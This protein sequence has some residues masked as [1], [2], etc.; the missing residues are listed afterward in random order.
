MQIIKSIYLN[1]ILGFLFLIF[2]P[3]VNANSI[4]DIDMDIYID[5]FGNASVKEIWTANLTSGTEGFKTYNDLGN[6]SITSFK[7]SDDS[8]TSYESLPSWNTSASFQEKAYKSG[9]HR[10]SGGLEL[11]WGI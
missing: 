2:I 5:S 11:C 10:V 1:F 4:D 9:I 8:G 7:V 6:A 3:L